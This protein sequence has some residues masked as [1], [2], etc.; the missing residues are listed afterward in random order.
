VGALDPYRTAEVRWFLRGPVPDGARAWFD[1][2]GPAPA[3]ESR[4]DR[5]LAPVSDG[6]SVKVREGR[7]EAKRRAGALGRLHIG[8]AAAPVEAWAKWSFALADAEAEPA[9]PWIAVAKTRRQRELTAPGGTCGLELADVEAEGGRWWSVCLEAT[10]PDDDARRAALVEGA[11]RWL[12]RDDAPA[13]PAEAAQG[14]P[15]WLRALGAEG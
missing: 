12:G 7:V 13:L 6:L 10:G 15:A 4:T 1:A 9:G 11:S 14:Y 3:P 2:L 8:R 5:Y